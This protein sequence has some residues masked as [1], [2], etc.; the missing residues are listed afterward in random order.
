MT[1]V[2]FFLENNKVSGFETGGHSS[3]DCDDEEGKTVCAAVSS[4]CYM[5]ANTVTEIIG[6]SACAD[7]RDGYMKF[8]VNSP[9]DKTAAVLSGLK[10]HIEQLSEQYSNRVRIIT[11]V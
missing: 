7:I 9:C 10:L 1:T 8:T 11:E 5:A 2:K 3:F 6:D 4:A